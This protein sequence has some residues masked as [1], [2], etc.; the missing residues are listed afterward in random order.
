MDLRM[1]FKTAGNAGLGRF[2]DA[3]GNLNVSDI[4]CERGMPKELKIDCTPMENGDMIVHIAA[5]GIQGSS[6]PYIVQFVS[7]ERADI[8]LLMAHMENALNTI[9]LD[10]RVDFAKDPKPEWIE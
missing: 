6:S 7:S 10:I 4:P 2:L 9:L 3:E 1:D 8:R 5:R